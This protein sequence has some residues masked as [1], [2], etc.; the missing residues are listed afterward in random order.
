MNRNDKRGQ[1]IE[2]PLDDEFIE[3]S[4]TLLGR[5]MLIQLPLDN[6]LAFTHNNC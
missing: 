6:C 2:L 3:W 1:E 4:K 5:M